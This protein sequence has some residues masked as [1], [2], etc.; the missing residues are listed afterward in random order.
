VNCQ[1]LQNKRANYSTMRL[2]TF[3]NYN[4][5]SAKT[6]QNSVTGC[7]F[8]T[9]GPYHERQVEASTLIDWWWFYIALVVVCIVL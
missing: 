6:A 2:V 9:R 8:E 4:K 7:V 3:H 1:K 5:I